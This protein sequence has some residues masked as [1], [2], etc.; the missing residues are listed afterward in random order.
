MPKE[1][2]KHTFWKTIFKYTK[3]NKKD[4]VLAVIFSMI[5]GAV[6]AIQP[7]VIKYIIDDAISNDALDAT[8]KITLAAIF[9]GAYIVLSMLRLSSWVIGFKYMLNGMEGF[10]FR[11][12]SKF[13]RHIQAL[14]MRFYDTTTSGEL[15]NYIMGTPMGSLKNFLHQFMVSIPYQ[16]VA[17]VISLS[18]LLTYDWLLTI[19]ML[20]FIVVT[21]LIN[22]HSRK[23]IRVLAKDLIKSESEASRYIGDVL[24]G[25]KAV[26]MYAIED[27]INLKFEDYITKM[28]DKG[29]KLSF[30]QYIENAKPDMF[31]RIGTACI[32]FVGAV[33][34]IYRGL[35]AGQLVA[36]VVSMEVI[37]ASLNVWFNITLVKSNAEAGL[38]R[39][40]AIIDVQSTTPDSKTHPRKI[41]VEK[42]HAI[43]KGLPCIE[44]DDVSFGY[45]DKKDILKNLNCK[46]DY[47]HCYGFAG[48]S[49]GGKTTVT[50]LIMR[51]YE[52]ER[53]KILIHGKDIKEFSI[54]D[55]RKC[56]GIVPQ[57]P[58]IFQGSVMENIKIAR[59]SASNY[60]VI[61]AMET[62][63]VHEFV[64][65]LP[66]GWNTIIGEEG[67]SLSGGQKQRLAIARAILGNP[68]ILIFDEA[69]SALDNISEKF[70]QQAMEELMHK[71]TVIIIAHRLTTIKNVDEIFVF[72]KGDIAQR[73]TFDELSNKEGLFKNMLKVTETK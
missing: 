72:D 59:P 69:T 22:K 49:G 7:F 5:T 61:Q 53:G 28:K 63:R 40:M 2:K 73:G 16:S 38:D 3:D 33:S 34:C 17:L 23:K 65:E 68:D 54:H 39:I 31:Q 60:E 30:T 44:F 45:D 11:L 58:Y 47:K 25:S 19:I 18:A 1:S 51:L 52:V 55:L 9:C 42:A 41:E 15:F 20:F 6:V 32:Y 24:H 46:M 43:S 48:A 12:R 21:V 8:Q 4:I 57:D 56:I 14:C 10:L 71:H 36:F 26:K 67:F 29:I 66:N 62:A 37:F 27:D 50:K 13:F 64:N 70:I 35:T